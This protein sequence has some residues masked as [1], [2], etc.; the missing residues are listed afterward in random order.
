MTDIQVC[1]WCPATGTP[2]FMDEHIKKHDAD[3]VLARDEALELVLAK[4]EIKR[5]KAQLKERQKDYAKTLAELVA[6]NATL[7]A[8][9]QEA[10]WILEG[11]RK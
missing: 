3:P 9:L 4:A 7:F 6:K 8:E 5:L 11:L 1:P 10:N 2:V